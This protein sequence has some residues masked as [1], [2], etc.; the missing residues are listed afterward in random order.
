[1]TKEIEFGTAIFDPKTHTFHVKTPRGEFPKARSVGGF[2]NYR[3]MD[4]YVWGLLENGEGKDGILAYLFRSSVDT[5]LFYYP[6]KGDIT[7]RC[8]NPESYAK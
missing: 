6:D 7:V 4:L 5:F 8:E 3:E 2:D 1:M